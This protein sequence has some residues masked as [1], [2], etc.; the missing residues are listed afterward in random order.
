MTHVKKKHHDESNIHGFRLS[1][2]QDFI[3][4]LH[5]PMQPRL[6]WKCGV[7]NTATVFDTLQRL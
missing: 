3:R 1:K 7:T 6:R 2:I 4:I 5:S